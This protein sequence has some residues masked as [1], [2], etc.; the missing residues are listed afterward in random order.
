[1]N[2]VTYSNVTAVS[3]YVKNNLQTNGFNNQGVVYINLDS[4]WSNLSDSELQQF[5]NFCHNNGQK[6]G[7]YWTT[8]VYW[9]TASQGSHSFMT[10]ASYRWSD[11]YL[12]TSTGLVQ[13]NDNGIALDPTHPGTRQMINHYLSYFKSHGFDYLKLDFLTHGAMEGVHFDTNVVT[14]IQ[15]Y[16]QGMQSLASQNTGPM[17]LSEAISPIFPYQYPPARRIY[18]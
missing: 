7:I 16:N 6:A 3:S 13:T 17:F 9:G 5:V 4:F 12:R 1:M 2:G 15:A 10:G 14:G 11:A 8:F 18:C